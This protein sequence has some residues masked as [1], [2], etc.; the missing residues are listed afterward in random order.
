LLQG[1]QMY[2]VDVLIE[3]WDMVERVLKSTKMIVNLFIF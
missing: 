3:F 2:L 1:G